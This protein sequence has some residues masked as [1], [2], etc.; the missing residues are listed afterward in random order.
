LAV[1]VTAFA[2]YTSAPFYPGCDPPELLKKF[3]AVTAILFIMTM[4]G[5]SVKLSERVQIF[6]TVAKLCLV[7]AIIVGGMVLMPFFYIL[8]IA[9]R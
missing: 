4:N 5:L 2:E 7:F 8:I 6:F 9:I 3:L 1:I